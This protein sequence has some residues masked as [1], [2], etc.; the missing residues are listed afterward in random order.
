MLSRLAMSLFP[1]LSLAFLSISLSVA[2]DA[3]LPAPS[4]EVILTV[5]GDVAHP[6]VGD[7]VHFDRQM[8]L[9]LSTRTIETRTPWH[10]Q[11]GRFEG[12][13]VRTVLEAAG[14]RGDRVRVHAL[15][16]FEAQIPVED[17]HEYDVLLAMRHEGQP[18]AIRDFGPL[19]VLYPF[20]HQPE[21]NNETIRFRSVWQVG[22]IHVESRQDRD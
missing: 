22:R 4:G 9:D 3:P 2:A 8:L 10:Q 12:P 6:N 21:L 15:N 1:T 5:T 16:D 19:F 20:D 17:F 14:A 13:L 18:M 11:P 7:E